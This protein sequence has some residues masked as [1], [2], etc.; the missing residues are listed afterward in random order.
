MTLR[1]ALKFEIRSTKHKTNP[2]SSFSNVQNGTTYKYSFFV[3]VIRILKIR[4]CFAFR[5]SDFGFQL[6]LWLTFNQI[7]SDRGLSTVFLLPFLG[8][9][10]EFDERD[11]LFFGCLTET[12]LPLFW[13]KLCPKMGLHWK[14]LLPA[15]NS[16]RTGE[17]TAFH[18]AIGEGNLAAKLGAPQF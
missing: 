3:L 12:P 6:A 1:F 9:F 14:I 18:Q 11:H 17:V 15:H 8:R 7:F 4:V 16:A 10:D 5:Y 13:R 2:K